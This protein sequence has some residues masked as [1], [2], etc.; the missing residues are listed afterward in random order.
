MVL[1]FS[2]DATGTGHAKPPTSTVEHAL[3]LI[4]ALLAVRDRH[5]VPTGT[6]I[7]PRAGTGRMGS[8][9]GQA[10]PVLARSSQSS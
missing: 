1:F 4:N 10:P 5:P 6:C 3:P 7:S 9:L 2:K 8:P